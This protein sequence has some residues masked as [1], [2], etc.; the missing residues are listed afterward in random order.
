MLD[1]FLVDEGVSRDRP[2]DG[3]GKQHSPGINGRAETADQQNVRADE[4]DTDRLPETSVTPASVVPT[5]TRT[6]APPRAI[7]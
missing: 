7:G 4:D 6:G 3:E 5:S 2:A 1:A